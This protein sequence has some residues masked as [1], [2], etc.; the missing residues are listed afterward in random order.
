[1]QSAFLDFHLEN[2]SVKY[3][4]HSPTRKHDN[5]LPNRNQLSKVCG[6]L[7]YFSPTRLMQTHLIYILLSS[8][9]SK[10]HLWFPTR[11]TVNAWCFACSF[12][13]SQCKDI[14][15]LHWAGV[16]ACQ[17]CASEAFFFFFLPELHSS[18]P[19]NIHH[20]FPLWCKCKIL[21]CLQTLKMWSCFCKECKIWT[22]LF[23][24]CT[25]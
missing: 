12:L 7:I 22:K 11:P 20:F 9:I 18:T 13:A 16:K 6:N 4:L 10:I 19:F 8:C 14:M 1:M 15:V 2:E 5:N 23:Q 24:V 17:S 3:R 21:Q 25:C